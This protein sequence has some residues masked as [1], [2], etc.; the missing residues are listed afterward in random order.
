[1][2]HLST[3]KGTD[4]EN[5][6]AFRAGE[7]LR[8][9]RGERADGRRSVT[10]MTSERPRDGMFLAAVQHGWDT[11]CGGLRA[12]RPTLTLSPMLRPEIARRPRWAGRE[13]HCGRLRLPY[14]RSL[15]GT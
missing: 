9:S 12:E 15:A 5:G 2:I 8:H 6:A 3:P 14:F 13:R 10:S 7:R 11:L 4:T 1:M